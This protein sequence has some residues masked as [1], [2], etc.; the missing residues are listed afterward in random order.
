MTAWATWATMVAVFATVYW[1]A[2]TMSRRCHPRGVLY[3]SVA[4]LCGLWIRLAWEVTTA[5]P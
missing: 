3:V 2:E 5:S 4:F 1:F